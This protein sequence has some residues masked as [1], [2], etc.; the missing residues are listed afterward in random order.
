MS[1]TQKKAPAPNLDNINLDL[2]K[3]YYNIMEVF[4]NKVVS[5]LIEKST[6]L[7]LDRKAL[8]QISFIIG[9][10]VDSAK[11]WGYDQLKVK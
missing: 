9:A 7:N 4:K 6:E 1:K 3:S 11:S 10:E 2:G 8:E 5:S